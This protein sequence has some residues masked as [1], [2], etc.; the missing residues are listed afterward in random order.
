[1]SNHPF[2]PLRHR[3]V[4]L[5]WSAAVF[6]DVGTWVQLIVVGSIVAADTGSAVLTGLVALAT[7][8]PQGVA[9]PIGGLLADRYDRR[10]V[11]A[12][13]LLVQAG[14]TSVLA[15]VLAL[16]VRQPVVLTLLIL[17]GSASGFIGS[18]SYAAMIPDLVAP[19]E[20]T[21]MVSLGVYSWNS[22]RIIGPLL[23]AALAT[24]VGPA[25]TVGFN[26]VTFVVLS[27]AVALVRR[28]FRPT[29]AGGTIGE[30]LADGWRTV[31]TSPGV[32]NA[33]AVMVLFNITMV[34]FMGLMPIYIRARFDGGAGLTGLVSS[35]QGIGAI[36]GGLLATVLAV[37]WGKS[38]LLG[39][40]IV[41]SS[42]ALLFYALAPTAGTVAAAA[43]LLGVG[44]STLFITSSSV[45]QRDAPPDKRGRVM[46]LMQ[47]SLGL[48]YGV[49]LLATGIIGD[50]ASLQVAFAIGA[51][52]MVAGFALFAWASP[53]WADAY[54]GTLT[55]GADGHE[56]EL[57]VAVS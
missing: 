17:L 3:S 18:P 30:R 21:A 32:G 50:S 29:V 12:T 7:F 40:A 41:Y 16:G 26:A 54:D 51:V 13:A 46:S 35:A 38:R 24:A 44:A 56:G 47:A 11:F 43:A 27:V 22:G 15:V 23:G 36:A 55:V 48:S 8:A 10:K 33:I 5:L 14:V 2:R 6:S 4:R 28:P 42:G 20:L 45:V 34:P 39:R 25:W 31:R 57:A 49:G 9:S 53:R 1:M 19:D 52:A 37:R